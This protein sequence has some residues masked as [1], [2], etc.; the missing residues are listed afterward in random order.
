L[1]ARASPWMPPQ[2]A[3]SA[4]AI[5]S[6]PL[7]RV[8]LPSTSATSSL[9]PSADAPWRSSFSRGRS[10]GDRSFIVL[11][12]AGING[13]QG[14]RGSL[15]SRGAHGSIGSQGSPGSQGSHGSRGSQ[16]SPGSRRSHGS[17]GSQG[18]HGSPGSL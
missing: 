9:S 17:P 16:G 7:A 4:L 13:S 1:A 11:Q 2:A 3:S 8:P 12:V 10:P 6:A 18:S 14:S 15:G 5:A